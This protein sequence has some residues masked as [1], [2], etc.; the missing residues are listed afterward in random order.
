M[1]VYIS[2]GLSWNKKAEFFFRKVFL[3]VSGFFAILI[4]LVIIDQT[5]T[6]VNM[7]LGLTKI[8]VIIWLTSFPLWIFFLIANN[9]IGLFIKNIINRQASK[10]KRA[11][12]SILLIWL[13]LLIFLVLSFLFDK[14]MKIA[15]D[16]ASY[17]GWYTKIMVGNFFAV[18]VLMPIWIFLIGNRFI[19]IV[20]SV[21]FGLILLFFL[22]FTV[23]VRPHKITGNSM[24]PTIVNG[25]YLVSNVLV[26]HFVAPQRG[27]IVIFKPLQ[28]LHETNEFV[29]RIVGLPGETISVKNGRVYIN[30]EI[31]NEPYLNPGTISDEGPMLGDIEVLIPKDNF[32]VLGDNRSNS[33]DSRYFGFVSKSSIVDR[34]WYV[35]WPKAKTGFIKSP[36]YGL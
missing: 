19:K 28:Q 10:K 3:I 6:I 22:I 16:P 5:N 11:G 24:Q 9:R 35:Y 30:R 27:D 15:L 12:V 36:N 2:K 4:P 33:N 20:A 32:V 13:T 17:K 21:V 8:F 14:N 7:T 1:D 23:L 29:A 26:Y 18:L 34:A 25:E 31:L